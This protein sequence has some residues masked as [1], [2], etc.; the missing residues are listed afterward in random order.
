M[1]ANRHPPVFVVLLAVWGGIAF[2]SV[3]HAASFFA[4]SDADLSVLPAYCTA[5]LKHPMGSPEWARWERLLG[6][7]FLHMHHY[8]FA[9]N[10]IRHAS[11]PSTKRTDRLGIYR[12]ALGDLDYMLDKTPPNFLLRPEILVKK[13]QT[14]AKIGNTAEAVRTLTAAIEAKPDWDGGYVALSDFYRDLGKKGDAIAVAEKG[15]QVVPSSRPLARRL[16]ELTG[17]AV[18][19]GTPNQ[20][21]SP[22]T[23]PTPGAS[24]DS[25]DPGSAP[26]RATP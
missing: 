1:N 3:L 14:L 6:P 13:G 26:P 21:P 7:G 5:R 22:V 17:R 15:F 24:P 16:S 2:S 12:M 18:A 11:L 9:Q 8:C 10:F 4:P 19:A 25:A 23:P 20:A